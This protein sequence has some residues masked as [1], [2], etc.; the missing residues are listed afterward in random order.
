MMRK[1]FA[2]IALLILPVSLRAQQARDLGVGFVLGDALGGSGKYWIDHISALDAGIGASADH[3][4][5]SIYGDYLYHGW[6]AFGQ[7][8]EGKLAAY[9]GGGPRIEARSDATE[10]GLRGVVGADYWLPRDPV[11]L[12]A[13]VGPLIR[14]SPNGGIY[15]IGGVGVRYYFKSWN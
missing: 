14:M 8:K 9:L 10:F 13:E 4:N 5:F 7:P 6:K 3:G 1:I 2:M 11:E 15:V 12:F